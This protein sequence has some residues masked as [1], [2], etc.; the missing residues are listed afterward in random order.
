MVAQI[1]QGIF[2]FEMITK[3]SCLNCEVLNDFHDPIQYSLCLNLP[4]Q[5]IP[6]PTTL[7]HLLCNG[8]D[9]LF[10]HISSTRHCPACHQVAANNIQ[11]SH[12]AT[13]PEILVLELERF[14]RV[15]GAWRKNNSPVSFTQNLDLSPFI[16]D[17]ATLKYRLI[18]VIHQRGSLTFGRYKVVTKTPGGKWEEIHNRAV[19]K[20][21]VG[22]ALNPAA[23]WMP[24]ILVY[25]RV[26]G[27]VS[28][29]R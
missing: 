17:T 25:T 2:G 8:T 19:S 20:V 4:Q 7:N 18:A 28:V 23:P 14:T 16:Y 12:F 9:G 11:F 6:T 10:D 3:S 21:R 1:L 29:R 15:N 27:Q 24:F 5:A 13:A 22:A 26:D